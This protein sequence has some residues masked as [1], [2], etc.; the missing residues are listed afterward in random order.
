MKENSIQYN[1]RIQTNNAAELNSKTRDGLLLAIRFFSPGKYQSLL[2][3]SIFASVLFSWWVGG[4][5]A[6]MDREPHVCYFVRQFPKQF[7]HSS[8]PCLTLWNMNK[9]FQMATCKQI[10]PILVKWLQ[11]PCLSSASPQALLGCQSCNPLLS[12]LLIKQNIKGRESFR[13]CCRHCRLKRSKWLSFRWNVRMD[14]STHF[15]AINFCD[16]M[17]K[18]LLAIHSSACTEDIQKVCGGGGASIHSPALSPFFD[19]L[20]L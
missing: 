11:Q 4:G 7:F 20:W 8:G 16:L 9:D 19:S 13:S 14:L 10:T 18:D 3:A 5:S 6:E 12:L 17:P 1:R 15:G 2:Q